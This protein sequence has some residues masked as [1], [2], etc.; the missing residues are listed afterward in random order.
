MT[1]METSL[2]SALALSVL[3]LAGSIAVLALLGAATRRRWT[4]RT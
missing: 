2:E 4:G 3:L 1:A